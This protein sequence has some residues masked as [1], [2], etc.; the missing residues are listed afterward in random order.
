MHPGYARISP[1]DRPDYRELISGVSA[2]VWPEFMFHDPIADLHWNGLFERFPTFQFAVLDQ[3]TNTVAGIANSVPLAWQ[4]TIE[5]LPDEGWDW[6]LTKSASDFTSGH[7][8]NMICAIQISVSPAFQRRGLSSILLSEMVE[9]ARAYGFPRLIAPVRPSKKDRYPLT[10]IESYIKWTGDD[11]LP[12]DPWL[13]VHVR[14]GGRILKPC[15]SAMRIVGTVAQWQEWTGLRFYES[16]QYI[17]PGALVPVTINLADD[18]GTY[19]EPNVWI[20]HEGPKVI[21]A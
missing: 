17:V 10:S 18:S 2:A 1:M 16:A 7:V 13:R 4:H 20:L 14:A 6:A 11:G 12:Y 21:A 15:P 8:P 19:I 3:K 5:Q 9:L